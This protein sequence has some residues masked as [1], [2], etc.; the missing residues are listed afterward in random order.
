MATD[1]PDALRTVLRK[2]K[3]LPEFLIERIPTDVSKADL[4]EE[5]KP[6]LE[7]VRG[8]EPLVREAFADLIRDRFKL[9]AATVKTLLRSATSPKPTSDQPDNSPDPRKGEVFEDTDHYYVL[10]GAA[11]SSGSGGGRSRS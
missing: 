1:G 8:S 9:K 4:G 11:S 10:G 5:L 2:A 6:V 3:R 7:L